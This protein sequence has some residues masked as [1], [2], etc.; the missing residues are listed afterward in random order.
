MVVVG[1]TA[2]G[3]TDLA[4]RL[5]EYYQTEIISF[6]SRQ[7]Y[8]EM[9]IGTASPSLEQLSRVRHH[10]IGDRSCII[11]LNAGAY[12]REASPLLQNL[13]RNFSTLV[14]VGGSGLFLRALTEGFD[15]M[16]PSD[17]GEVRQ[18]WTDFFLEK[19]IDALQNEIRKRDP[20]YTVTADMNNHQRLIRA[21]EVF[22]LTGRPYSEHRR[23]MRKVL[24]Y[25]LCLVG[26]NPA[27]HVLHKRIEERTR[28]MIAAGL[29][30]EAHQLYTKR[31]LKSLQTVGY[32]EW[33]QHF[34]GL[35]PR[36]QVAEQILFHTRSYARRQI[37]WF[38]KT[39]GIRWFEQ[40][41]D[42][43]I[44]L[45]IECARESV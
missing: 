32:S 22:Q 6:D 8:H 29:E 30:M 42:P 10:F 16:G 2:S 43:E 33:F 36:N 40:V 14:A 44:L 27:R 26:L 34:A 12:E 17:Q 15:D 35:L 13:F 5:A 3:K 24:P 20:K 7:F 23:G 18:F 39:E 4:I 9:P 25:H 19:G 41:E 11:P 38:R 1:P 21:L 31:H 45:H 37:T 28:Y